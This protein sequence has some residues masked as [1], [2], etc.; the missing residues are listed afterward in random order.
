M[1]TK[2]WYITLNGARFLPRPKTTM[3]M[4][5]K[6]K[7][8]SQSTHVPPVNKRVRQH[9]STLPP[10]LEILPQIS[11][12][13]QQGTACTLQRPVFPRVPPASATFKNPSSMRNTF[14]LSMSQILEDTKK[15]R[16]KTDKRYDVDGTLDD[17][18]HTSDV[19]AAESTLA[20]RTLA[21]EPTF[22]AVPTSAPQHDNAPELGA[23]SPVD[24][25][26]D[27]PVG[28]GADVPHTTST[29]EPTHALDDSTDDLEPAHDNEKPMANVE[30]TDY[31]V[32]QCGL[33]WIVC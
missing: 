16:R 7:R 10:P 28:N 5:R 26:V 13:M 22:C 3:A 14:D 8:K 11:D 30:R 29:P 1:K 31:T 17:V 33:I 23:H 6:K 32:T 21:S 25:V 27:F 20:E 2:G 4:R 19:N 12:P 18:N 15:L 24:Q 9:P